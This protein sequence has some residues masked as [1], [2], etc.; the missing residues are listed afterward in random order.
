MAVLERKSKPIARTTKSVTPAASRSAVDL[1]AEDLGELMRLVNETSQRLQATHESLQSEVA[2]LKNEL[3]EANAALNRS[4]AL[5]A[6]G[7]MAAGIAHEVRNP[8]GSI[9]LYAQMLGEDLQDRP[10]Q[11]DICAKINRAVVGLDAIVHDVLSFAREMHI[12]PQPTS[13]NE[14]FSSA[15]NQCAALLQRGINVIRLN[16]VPVQFHA[17][18]NLIVQ[19]LGN[20]IRNAIEAMSESSCET[21][22][23]SLGAEIRCMRSSGGQTEERAVLSIRDTGPGIP[24]HVIE[25]VFNPFFTT[26]ATGT[27]LGL[28]IVHRI[29]D[30]HGGQ[31][32]IESPPQGGTHVQLCLPVNP[33]EPGNGSRGSA[34]PAMRPASARSHRSNEA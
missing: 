2:R 13:D 18:T 29:V 14:L 9:Q 5:A 8:L 27:G 4:K 31:T 6:L 32:I 10:A 30:A 26:R 7:E 33:R 11:A 16:Q 1:G 12:R 22:T 23:L 25:R 28:A 24:A 19:A 20:V 17:D 34:R 21:R 3:A 15:L